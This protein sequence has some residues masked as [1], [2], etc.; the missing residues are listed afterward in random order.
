M[1]SVLRLHHRHYAQNRLAFC[2]N[3]VNLRKMSFFNAWRKAAVLSA[4]FVYAARGTILQDPSQLTPHKTYDY[5]IAGA[6]AAG[7]VLASRLSENS[8]VSVLLIEAGSSDYKNID[9]EVPH[10]ASLLP[11]TKFDW[12]FTTAPQPGLN[13]RSISYQRGHV[14][15]G[16]TSV[17]YMVFTRGSKDDWDRFA[18]VTNDEGWS[19][20]SILP[21]AKKMEHFVPPI[22]GRNISDEVELSVHGT[23]GPLKSSVP[24]ERV[25]T[26]SRV[27]NTTTELSE[28]PFN[29]DQNSGSTIGIGWTQSSIADGVRQSAALAYLDPIMARHNLDIVVNTQ[30][31]K[32]L[33]TGTSGGL[34]VFRGVHLSQTGSSEGKVY[35]LQATREVIVSTGAVK[36]PQL[37]MLSG[38]GDIGELSKFKIKTIVNLPDVGKNLQDQPLI[39]SS[40]TVNSTNTLDSLSFDPTFAAQQLALWNHNHTGEL[41]MIAGSQIGWLRLPENSSI[42]RTTHDPSAGPTSAHF[43][44]I[45][46]DGLLAF[47]PPFPTSGNFFTATTVVI[48]PSSRGTISLNSTDPFDAPVIQP[49]F[50]S[51]GFDIFTMRESI[52]AARRFA[53]A[54]AWKD[55]I[56]AEFGALSQAQ[57]DAEID[58]YVRNNAVTID[59]VTC[60]A[61]MGKTGSMGA[62]TGVLNSDLTVKGTVGLRVVDA[63]AFPYVPAAHTQV[64]TYILAERAADLIKG[65]H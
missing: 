62:G 52:K 43:E 58:Q 47:N 57:T 51:T 21:Y 54:P 61:A 7:S 32:L 31:T 39:T 6:G 5:I 18:H 38:I 37:L 28:F 10:F 4:C 14:L 23:N 49:A 24:G 17:N 36:T 16:S 11:N 55:W 26:D 20:D 30:V 45:L 2:V 60:T 19:W 35:T 22:D 42:F 63:S 41:G 46:Y 8:N 1:C 27:L 44:L 15:G 48:S 59:H 33:Q 34:P 13:G 3:T 65:L 9:I 64:P 53:A 12:N 29:R 40:F 25:S 56:V 50:L